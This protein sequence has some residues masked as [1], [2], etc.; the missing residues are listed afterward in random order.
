MDQGRIQRASSPL[1]IQGWQNHPT[2]DQAE[3][4]NAACV[5]CL[6]LCSF[7]CVTVQKQILFIMCIIS[8]IGLMH[9]S[10]VVVYFRMHISMADD[11]VIDEVL[12]APHGD[13]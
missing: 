1:L 11:T 3:D 8:N 2:V 7:R 4:D 10:I 9:E 13:T 6:F 5:K 12:E